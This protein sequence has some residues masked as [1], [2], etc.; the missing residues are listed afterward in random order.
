[1]A[2]TDARAVG[3]DRIGRWVLRDS[4]S[5]NG[6][7]GPG[8]PGGTGGGPG[9]GASASTP[10]QG[11]LRNTLGVNGVAYDRL[12]DKLNGDPD[13]PRPDPRRVF[14]RVPFI[15]PFVRVLVD[16]EHSERREMVLACRN[17]SRGGVALLHSTFMYPGTAVTVYLQRSD[18]SSPGVRGKVVR[19][20]HRCGV[21][22]E[23]GVRFDR[24]I[25][26]RDYGSGDITESAPSVE[27]VSPEKLVGAVV[28]VAASTDIRARVGEA[29]CDTGVRLRFVPTA[30]AAMDETDGAM[31]MMLV[32]L[33]LPEMS[34]A[35]LVKKIRL[36]GVNRPVALIGA[37]G[38]GL[39]RSMVRVCGADALIPTPITTDTMLRTMGEF[40]LSAWDI[41]Q[42]GKARARL[43]RATLLS[44]CFELNKLGD[45]M[46]QQ[47]RLDDRV[48]L[49]ATCRK[50]R[51][52]A[53]LVGMNGVASMA[54]RL[55]DKATDSPEMTDLAGLLDQV[56]MGCQAAGRAAA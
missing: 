8:G 13:D 21:V 32:E 50:V 35:E 23:I 25:N 29:L 45:T 33:D 10:P 14:T 5:S 30:Q 15:E 41:N 42:L 40:M 2:L 46:E 19:V 28:L 47:A 43:D 7:S 44:L 9:A 48:A 39:S 6:A 26:A 22:H 54:E 55:A 11:S 17:L 52:L 38:A 1:M 27:R 16:A 49:F 31:E 51:G 18:G 37:P 4:L 12:I 20:Q 24:E 34:G 53:L 3:I 56:R 36:R